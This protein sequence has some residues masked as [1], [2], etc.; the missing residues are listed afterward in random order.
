M[1]RA[2]LALVLMCLSSSALAEERKGRARV[3][4]NGLYSVRMVEAAQGQ[5]RL[6]VT[7][8]SGPVWTLAQ[9][10]GTVDDLYFVSNDGERV[11]V[12]WPLVEKGKPVPEPRPKKKS[13]VKKPKGPPAWA[14]VVVAAQYGR[15]GQRLQEKRLTEWLNTRQ[16]S[17]V[18]QLTH[19]FKWLEGTLGIPGKGPRLTDAG[20]VE[21]E[22]VGVT[23]RQLTF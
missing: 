4:A 10:L 12:V 15:D 23:T 3:S 7:Q 21:L 9:C 6:E 19:H 2:A 1:R 5:C 18:R 11:W 22:P 13:K 16:L 8:E 20:V 14:R 17:E